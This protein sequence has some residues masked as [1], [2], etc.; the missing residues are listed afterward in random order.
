MSCPCPRRFTATGEKKSNRI[1]GYG[2]RNGSLLSMAVGVLGMSE[3][4]LFSMAGEG[5]GGNTVSGNHL[6]SV[7]VVTL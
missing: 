1:C 5:G 3:A 2:V 7:F 4:F 6:F